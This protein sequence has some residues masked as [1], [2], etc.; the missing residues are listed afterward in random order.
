[1]FWWELEVFDE[2]F[3]VVGFQ[4]VVEEVLDEADLG[5]EGF[6][7]DAWVLW[8]WGEESDCLRGTGIM[9]V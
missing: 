8:G 9:L 3:V 1:M 2:G 5:W 4:L 7:C 6:G